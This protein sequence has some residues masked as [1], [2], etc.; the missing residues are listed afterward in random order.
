MGTGKWAGFN[1][2]PDLTPVNPIP[3]LRLVTVG[4]GE[5]RI[6]T[7]LTE[8]PM[9]LNNFLLREANRERQLLP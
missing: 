5:G 4:E 1:V 3:A 8:G 7:G 2:F 9:V 6:A